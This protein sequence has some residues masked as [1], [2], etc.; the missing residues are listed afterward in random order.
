MV[1]LSHFGFGII[2]DVIKGFIILFEKRNICIYINSMLYMYKIN[3]LSVI[4][5]DSVTLLIG[6]GDDGKGEEDIAVVVVV[7]VVVR[8]G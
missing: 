6:G 7:V 8:E 5:S 2:H 3:Y 4:A 1:T